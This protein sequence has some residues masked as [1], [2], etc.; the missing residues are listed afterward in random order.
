MI[1]IDVSMAGGL[2]EAK[3]IADLADLYC[4]PVATHNVAGPIATVASACLAASVREFLGHEIFPLPPNASAETGF[5]VNGDPRI[6][7]YDKALVKDGYIQLS[8]R[9]GL[10]IEL[11]ED[12]VRSYLCEGET[13]WD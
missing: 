9:P 11:D 3:K 2:L 13:W 4:L 6:L 12:L 10:G 8:D 5:G 7:G 1:E